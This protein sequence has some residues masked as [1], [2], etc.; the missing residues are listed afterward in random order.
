MNVNHKNRISVNWTLA[1]SKSAYEHGIVDD[2]VIVR[3]PMED[4]WNVLLVTVDASSKHLLCDA[5]D[6]RPRLFKTLDAAVRAVETVGFVVAS[7]QVV[8]P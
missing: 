7:L 4:G 2:A 8:G 5:H 6:K 3:A 1:F